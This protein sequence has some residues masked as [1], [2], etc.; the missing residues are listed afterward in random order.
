MMYLF[1]EQDNLSLKTELAQGALLV[2][3]HI[4]KKKSVRFA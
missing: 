3:Q 4:C 2:D 1:F